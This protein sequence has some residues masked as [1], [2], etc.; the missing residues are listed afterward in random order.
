M[1]RSVVTAQALRRTVASHQTNSIEWHFSS[2]T[3]QNYTIPIPKVA[4]IAYLFQAGI[5]S[6]HS[7]GIGS[8][9]VIMSKTRL[10]MAAPV[11]TKVILVH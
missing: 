10:V 6:Y 3:E 5:W 9:M 2:R 8:A 4:E 7:T 1:I 11:V